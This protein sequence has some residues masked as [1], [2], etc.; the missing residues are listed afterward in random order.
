MRF[1]ALLLLCCA[2][3]TYSHLRPADNLRSGR[4]EVSA[5]FAASTLPEVVPVV[6][7]AVGITDWLE[8]EAQYE[9]YS[10]LGELRFGI[11]RSETSAVALS[12]GVGGGMASVWQDLGGDDNFRDGAVLG[13][14]VVGKRWPAV[15]IYLA[16]RA[17]VLLSTGYTI[18]AVKAGVRF[19]FR[20]AHLGLEG[21]VTTHHSFIAL[22]EG[23]A[24]VGF[25]L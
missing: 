18:N 15:E 22:G 17:I 13:D 19:R 7:G 21:G 12:V 1:A 14:V 10:A 20:G 9:V 16:D 5:G 4:V 3:G 23:T 24:F 11:L 8:L 2:C 6:Q 25:I